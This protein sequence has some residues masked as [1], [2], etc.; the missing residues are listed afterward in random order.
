M[1]FGA[2]LLASASV[3]VVLFEA[4]SLGA[5][6]AWVRALLCLPFIVGLLA[7][8]PFVAYWLDRF[9]RKNVGLCGLLLLVVASTVL[10]YRHPVGIGVAALLL[11]EGAGCSLVQVALGGTMANDLVPSARRD[12]VDV[13][14]ALSGRLGLLLSPLLLVAINLSGRRWLL[15]ALPLAACLLVWPVRL[16]FRAPLVLCR[17]STDR[18]WLCRSLWLWLSVVAVGTSVGV[19]LSGALMTG[20]DF[21]S[22][23]GLVFLLSLFALRPAGYRFQTMGGFVLLALCGLMAGTG[24]TL[25]HLAAIALLALGLGLVTMGQLT[26]FL[27]L[28]SH[29]QRATAQQTFYL[30]WAIGLAAGLMAS[31]AGAIEL[32]TLFWGTLLPAVALWGGFCLSKACAKSH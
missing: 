17:C 26:A 25:T 28:S 32:R 19:L 23:L 10:V 31:V 30:G 3:P 22:A 7:V 20:A 2:N 18:F 27:A 21:T 29:C 6:P 1:L 13:H 8:G 16:P 12:R 4:A 5:G 14:F 15:P 11:A 9:K 24:F